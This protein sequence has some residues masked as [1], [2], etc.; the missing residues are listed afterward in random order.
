M[1]RTPDAQRTKPVGRSDWLWLV[2]LLVAVLLAAA[3]DRHV[4]WLPLAWM[5][6]YSVGL[7][8]R[9]AHTRPRGSGHGPEP[10][11]SEGH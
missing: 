7:I 9:I 10:G 11:Q 8:S 3:L 4:L 5:V 1:Q 6:A 2:A